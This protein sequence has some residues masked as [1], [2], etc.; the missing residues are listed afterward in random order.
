V[1]PASK[2]MPRK[3]LDSG[4]PQLIARFLLGGVF[5]YM[6]IL[7]LGDPM[8]FLK[9]IRQYRALP[10][11]PPIFLNASAIVLPW[12]EVICGTGLILGMSMRGASLIASIMLAVF[13]PAILMRGLE[14]RA[15]ENI[16]FFQVAFDCGCGTGVVVTWKKLLENVTLFSLAVFVLVAARDRFTVSSLVVNRSS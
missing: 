15:Q 6:G 8:E 16:S 4:W 3:L 1:T 2:T 13:T 5:I 14:I 10:E 9:V 7:K 12:L 11:T